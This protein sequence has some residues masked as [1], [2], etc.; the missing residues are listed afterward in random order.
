[1]SKKAGPG[2]YV[3]LAVFVFVVLFPFFW[4]LLASFKPPNELFGEA[5]FRVWIDN[6]TLDN[7]VRVFSQRPFFD[8]PVEQHRC[9]HADHGILPGRRVAGRLCAGTARV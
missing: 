1:M 7:Y 4:Q 5:A 9:C 8:I 2:F 6:P 3:F